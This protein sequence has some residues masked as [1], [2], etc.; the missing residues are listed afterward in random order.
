[1]EH[2]IPILTG[3]A[4]DAGG[5]RRNFLHRGQPADYSA[6]GKTS[7]YGPRPIATHY[8]RVAARPL[9]VI[10]GTDKKNA[11]SITRRFVSEAGE[12]AFTVMEVLVVMLLLAILIIASAAGIIAMDKSSRRLADYTA[13]MSVAEAKIQSIRAATYQ[14]P[15]SPFGAS[16]V[17]LTNNSSISLAK[18]GTNF[19]VTGTVLSTIQPVA[20]GHLVTV[21]ATFAEPDRSFSVSLQSLVNAYTGG[22]Q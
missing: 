6:F 8:E 10:S 3:C 11:Q 17:Y 21:T 4:E 12:G 9:Q 13:A 19:L 14:P 2:A 16:T 15:A 22:E 20:A 7:A 1:M 18:S 5:K